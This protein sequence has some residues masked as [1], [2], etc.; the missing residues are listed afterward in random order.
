[1]GIKLNKKKRLFDLRIRFNYS[2]G[3]LYLELDEAT[4]KSKTHKIMVND[5]EFDMIVDAS[6]KGQLEF[7]SSTP[8]VLYKVRIK[9][10][11]N[12]KDDQRIVFYY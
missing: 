8:R 10:K 9:G 1:M 11:G 6:G 7:D 2:S 5:S 4:M 12:L 3:I